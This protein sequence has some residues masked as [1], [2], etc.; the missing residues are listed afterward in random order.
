MNKDPSHKSRTDLLLFSEENLS[1]WTSL[2]DTIMGGSSFASCNVL[3]GG[4]ILDGFLVEDGGGFVSC[5]SPVLDPPLNLS[6]FSGFDLEVEGEGRTLKL[7]IGC[8]DSLLGLTDLFYGGLRWIAV[9]PTEESGI[10]KI[11][12]PFKNLQPTVRAKPFTFP[13]SF[14]ETCITQLQLLY[15]KFGQAGE[16]NQEFRP[17]PIRIKLLSIR[18]FV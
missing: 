3:E 16:L 10:T 6:K 18:A 17:G 9:I 4:L 1:E 2:N 15:S 8:R 14:D 11:K 12:I 7:A 13:I 5:R